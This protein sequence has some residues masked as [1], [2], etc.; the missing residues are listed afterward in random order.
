MSTDCCS[1]QITWWFWGWRRISIQYLLDAIKLICLVT[2]V[3]VPRGEI[4]CTNS[5]LDLHIFERNIIN[6]PYTWTNMA[7]FHVTSLMLYL[8]YRFESQ[9]AP[10]WSPSLISWVPQAS[11]L[12]SNLWLICIMYF[13]KIASFPWQF[14]LISLDV[15]ISSQRES[16][17]H[18]S[19]ASICWADLEEEIHPRKPDRPKY[20]QRWQQHYS[21][22]LN[23]DLT[24][25]W[26][27]ISPFESK[28]KAFYL[29]KRICYL[30]SMGELWKTR[31]FW[32]WY[33]KKDLF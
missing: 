17:E 31:T 32:A 8:G 30:D 29:R 22:D 15:L 9:K 27:P 19:E 6:M 33:G 16:R 28:W 23:L 24:F 4:Q 13:R 26:G 21:V 1:C 14:G 20:K 5:L 10:L 12:G 18:S 7:L 25:G 3:R 11:N 2:K